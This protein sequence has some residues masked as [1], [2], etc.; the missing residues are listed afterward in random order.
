MKKF[1]LL[2]AATLAL[3]GCA[4]MWKS[5]GVATQKTVDDGN[6]DV[7]TRIGEIKASVDQLAA[8]ST[9]ISV[10]RKDIDE[11]SPISQEVRDLREKVDALALAVDENRSAMA[12]MAGIKEL[13]AELQGK[14]DR[15]PRE[16]IQKLADI[17]SK[18]VEELSAAADSSR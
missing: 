7:L 3:S 9:E 13:L 16:T 2:L 15:L 1:V 8:A 14:T 18:A 17:L 5:L 11:L 4:S 6:A 10:L 12:E